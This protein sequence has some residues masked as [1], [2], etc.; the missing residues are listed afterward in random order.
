VDTGVLISAYAFGGS[1]EKA[2][3]KV[4][5]YADIYLS[6]ELLEEYRN[7]PLALKAEGKID[8]AQLKALISGIAAFVSRAKIVI[9]TKKL[10]ICRDPEDNMILEC[11][12]AAKAD[13]LITGDKDLLDIHDLPFK[14]KILTPSE[15]IKKG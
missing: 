5:K 7:V 3:K 11:C 4:F 13:I 12:L 8:H 2:V 14:L 1:P 15:F 6:P 9:P 10:S